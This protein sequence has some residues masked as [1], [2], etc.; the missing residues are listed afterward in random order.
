MR[1]LP[2]YFPHDLSACC[3]GQELAQKAQ[4]FILCAGNIN[5]CRALFLHNTGDVPS[6]ACRVH[7]VLLVVLHLTDAPGDTPA[8]FIVAENA[9]LTCFCKSGADVTQFYDG[10]MDAVGLDFVCQS[11]RVRG[12]GGFACGVEGLERNVCYG[13]NG[14]DVHNMPLSLTA[15]EGENRFIYSDC[16]EKVHIELCFGLLQGGKLHRTGNAKACTVDHCINFG[17]F[18]DD[19]LHSGVDRIFIGH[20]DRQMGDALHRDAPAAELI[21]DAVVLD[22]D[23]MERYKDFTVDAQRFPRFADFAAEMKAQ[24]IHLV[25][26]I[27]AAVKVEDG[28]DVYEEGVKNGYFCTNRDGTPFVAGVWPGRVHFP[29]ML[30]P[31]AR[32][33]FGSQY[34]VLLDQG[35]EGFWNDMNEP[36]IFYAEER[37]K[38]TFAQIEKYS[39]QNLDISSFG[40]FT[41][42]VAELS[43][44]ENDYKL[45]YH[46]TKQGRMRHDKV[47]NLFGYNM[48]RAAGEA[49]ERLEPDKRIL[50]YSRSA[51][52]GM[53]R[54]G[55]IW[56]GDNHS[57]WSHIL[58]ALH[59]MPSL[60]MCGFL[61]EG[62]DIGG[63]GSNT[64]E[65]LVLRW[66]GL[67]IFS[68]LLRNHSANGTR[69]QEPYRFKNKAAFAGIL[70]LR[71]LLLP[72]IYSE[73]M[74]AA[75]HDGM[76][77]MPLAFAFP[78][79]DFARRVED[80]VMIGESL[81]IAPVYEQNARGRYVYLPEEML[82]VRVKCNESNRI[83]TSVLPAGHH[84]IPVELDEVV[85]FMRKGHLL[86]L[87]KDGKKIQSVADVDF[88][89]LRLLAYAPDG[90]SYEYYTDDGE[91]K[92]YDKPEHFVH[93][94]LDADGNAKSD[95][96][97]VKVEG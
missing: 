96:A 64:T 10:N 48:T 1:L 63:F 6:N 81:L 75:L 97:T 41:G 69:R 59:M 32:A 26:I 66:Y 88:A 18:L 9:F 68:P 60:N 74:K 56:T 39:K 19:L 55:G 2:V 24:G 4:E 25:P 42:M 14:A 50:I 46:N 83:E 53:H 35:I 92:D 57:W 71:Y 21:N 80:E 82:Q 37:L 79:D 28:Y 95:R 33:W 23:Y 52:I 65:D 13:G 3:G 45:F 27:D 20:I 78:E 12:N 29:D 58:L 8:V 94:T 73:Y 89:D 51:C 70:Q 93:I 67:G 22:I 31:E 36:A 76:Y 62:P 91:T 47:H 11:V 86:P 30:N 38:K 40:A 84:Y 7:A 16:P 54:Y 34:K 90:A 15:Q 87:A 44:N 61:Y 49:F 77:C 43:N 5:D 85:F 72:Y 17:L